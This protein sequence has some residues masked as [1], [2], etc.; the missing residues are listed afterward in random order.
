MNY[1]EHG[2]SWHLDKSCRLLGKIMVDEV[3]HG[4][5]WKCKFASHSEWTDRT[6]PDAGLQLRVG[7]T[8]YR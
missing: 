6:I 2:R 5:A 1:T 8:L 4:A 7:T 3:G